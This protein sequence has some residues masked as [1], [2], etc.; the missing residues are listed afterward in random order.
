[1]RTR[2]KS[3]RDHTKKSKEL[4]NREE[5]WQRRI[6][7]KDFN[8]KKDQ[9]KINETTEKWIKFATK[10]YTRIEDIEVQDKNR[11][12]PTP[13]KVYSYAGASVSRYYSSYGFNTEAYFL[14]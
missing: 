12:P 3:G 10:K 11:P 14:E 8:E 1:M 9:K 6:C 13:K 5:I 7:E 2:K 4:K